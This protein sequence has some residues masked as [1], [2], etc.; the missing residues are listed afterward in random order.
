M[1]NST[2]EVV[3]K[4]LTT[5]AVHLAL[6]DVEVTAYVIMCERRYKIK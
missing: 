4:N 2:R 6:V 5:A 3:P 1:K